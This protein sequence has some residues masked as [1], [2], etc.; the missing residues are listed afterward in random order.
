MYVYDT[1]DTKQQN[2]RPLLAEPARL[3]RWA[4][5]RLRDDQDVA[6]SSLLKWPEGH[7]PNVAVVGGTYIVKGVRAVAFRVKQEVVKDGLKRRH[8]TA[9]I[10]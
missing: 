2:G 6:E 1:K 7:L 10:Y 8:L 3:A 4:V 9:H 5:E